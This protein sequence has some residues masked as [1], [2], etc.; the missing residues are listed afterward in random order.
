MGKRKPGY[1][2]EWELKSR[3]KLFVTVLFENK[4]VYKCVYIYMNKRWYFHVRILVC[5]K[6]L[7]ENEMQFPEGVLSDFKPLFL[8]WLVFGNGIFGKYLVI[9][10]VMRVHHDR[11]SILERMPESLLSLPCE[12]TARRWVSTS[13]EPSLQY[14]PTIWHPDLKL[15]ASKSKNSVSFKS[16]SLWYIVMV[17]QAD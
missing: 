6:W 17:A 11:I 4:C 7:V 12:D 3:E 10:E 16:P 15:L 8:M 5:N 14:H 9:D 1:T 13:Q 2:E